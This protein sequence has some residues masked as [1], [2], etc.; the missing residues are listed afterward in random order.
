VHEA[1]SND[2]LL[3]VAAAKD[4]IHNRR[5]RIAGAAKEYDELRLLKP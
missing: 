3:S 2:K 1:A 5:I 4:V